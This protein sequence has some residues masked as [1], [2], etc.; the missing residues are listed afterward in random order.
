MKSIILFILLCL[1]SELCFA[2]TQAELNQDAK[3]LYL[4]SEKEKNA[5]Y[6]KIL[7]Q[8][9]A[10]LPFIKNLKSAQRLWVQLRDADMKMK[11]PDRQAGYYGSM[12]PMCWYNYMT[13][14]TEQRIRTL[15]VWLAGIEEGDGCA[16]SVKA[17]D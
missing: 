2:Q 15:R 16:G 14:L 9:S 5:I 7:K 6:Q 3:N 12:K 11:F 1:S 10:D 17:K 8:Y 4:K 13:E